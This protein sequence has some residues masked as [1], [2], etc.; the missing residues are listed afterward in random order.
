MSHHSCLKDMLLTAVA[1]VL[2]MIALADPDTRVALVSG[3]P[4]PYFAA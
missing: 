3:G 1:A 4:H 2:P